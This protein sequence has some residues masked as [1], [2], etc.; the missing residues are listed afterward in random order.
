MRRLFGTNGIRG[1]SNKDMNS[2]LA[3]DIGK[4]IATYYIKKLKRNATIAI[5]TDARTS[6]MMLKTASISGLLS[7][8]CDVVDVGIL[9]TPAL[10]YVVKAKDFDAGIIITASHNPPEF[11][12]IKVVDGDGT[13]LSAEQEEEIEKIYFDK[14]F[15][16]A[17][18]KNIG[19]ISYLDNAIDVYIKGV[20]SKV[21]L[22]LIKEKKL[23]VVLDCGNGAGSL[24]EPTLL[25]K[26]GCKVTLLNC[27]PNGFFP[28]R[29]SEP[30]IENVG[31]LMQTVKD[32]DA[33]L[34]IALDGDADRAIFVD[35]KG[36]YVYGDKTLALMGKYI[37]REHKGGIVVTPVSTSSCLEDV[38]K[39]E[40]GKV[41]YTAVGSP[42]VAR[43]MIKTKAVFGGEENGG[44]IFPEHQY[45]RD[46]AISAAKVIEL[47]A[48]EKKS[49]SEL[50]DEIPKYELVKTKTHCPNEKKQKVMEKIADEVKK[51]LDIKEIDNTDGVKIYLRE[52]WIL[53]R[54]S[55]TEPIFRIFAESK[56]KEKAEEIATH[57][58]TL[59]EKIV[60]NI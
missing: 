27:E 23:H 54:P 24:V 18:W 46:A 8:G 2:Y 50:I 14:S 45:C 12:G 41:I 15:I 19:K 16:A 43:V 25:K 30:V 4:A 47:I 34:G 60:E 53:I 31:K 5:G 21:D 29:P 10:Q 44:L 13:E 17:D 1:I 52:G 11:N 36:R 6:N 51:E 28:G 42:I 33:D 55:G 59:L 22:D 49:L 32:V 39:K 3:L 37:V 56:S 26:L 40:G 9:P 57:Y 58:K 35:E 38:V 20:I 7:T 48:R